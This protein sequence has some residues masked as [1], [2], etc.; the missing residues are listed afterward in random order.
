MSDFATAGRTHPAGFAHR[1]GREVV[2]Q[3]EAFLVGAL[4]RVDPLL[5][6]AGAE[7]RNHQRLGFTPSEERR[8]VRTR[9]NRHFRHNRADLV[10][11]TSVH[12]SAVLDDVTTQDVSF[13]FLERGAE[14]RAVDAV[15]IFVGLDQCLGRLSLGGA[16]RVMTLGLAGEG[17]AGPNVV[18]DHRLDLRDGVGEVLGL[19][20]PG[21]LRGVFCEFDDRLDDR[22]EALV[23]EGDCA[24][25]F[26]FVHLLDFRFHHHHGVFGAGDNQIDPAVSHLIQSRVQHVLT[27]DE[28][29]ARSADRAH[30]RH[31]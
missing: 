19:E 8:S 18:A 20:V 15:G 29:D 13:A 12:A 30:E 2:V 4:Q 10:E 22:L 9:Q 1:I 5:V 24:Q 11:W 25:D 23:R 3:Q 17:I 16:D 7:G 21:L 27:V 28:A 14:L 31:A 26:F 6:I